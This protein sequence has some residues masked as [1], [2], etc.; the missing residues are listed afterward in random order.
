MLLEGYEKMQRRS[1]PAFHKEMG[2]LLSTEIPPFALA[3]LFFSIALSILFLLQVE[4]AAL[5]TWL[6]PLIVIGYAY[7]L[8]GPAPL[9]RESLFPSEQYVVGTYVGNDEKSSLSTRETLLLGWHRYLVTEWAHEV[10]SENGSVF[11]EQL[12]GGLFAFNT[13]RLKW[14]IDGKGDEMIVAGFNTPPSFLRIACYFLWNLLFA[15]F[16]NRKGRSGA[17]QL[18]PNSSI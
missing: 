3:W 17:V 5:C 7:F 9:K 18:A 14:V 13:A 12:D 1:H 15:W 16:I 2:N 10:P 8:N 4:G 6:L 11:R